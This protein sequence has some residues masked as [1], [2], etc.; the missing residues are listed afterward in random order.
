VLESRLIPF[1]YAGGCPG[2]G[3][4]IL[5]AVVSSGR[6][7]LCDNATVRTLVQFKWSSYGRHRFLKAMAYYLLGLFGLMFLLFIR[8]DPQEGLTAS[9][10]LHG[11]FRHKATF[12]ATLLL[13]VESVFTL[14]HEV[15]QARLIGVQSYL[16]SDR[17]NYVDIAIV[18]LT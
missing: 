16:R 5:N 17:K 10:L 12:V 7:S 13:L 1:A 11:D 8:T 18:L 9:A 3:N 14:A 2:I 6:P 15:H 4:S